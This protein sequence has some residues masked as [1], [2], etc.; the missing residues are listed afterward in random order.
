[1][2]ED[3]VSGLLVGMIYVHRKSVEGENVCY[4]CLRWILIPKSKSVV[5]EDLSIAK[6][7]KLYDM[8]MD[9]EELKI[10]GIDEFQ[11][12]FEKIKS[13]ETAAI[14]RH[15]SIQKQKLDTGGIHTFVIR[16]TRFIYPTFSSD[17][18]IIILLNQVS[19]LFCT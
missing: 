2:F 18:L 15:T 8:Y 7:T 17:I 9:D 4:K 10:K 5:N 1:M 16:G 14:Q 13:T 6:K 3:I 19:R 12:V 11:K